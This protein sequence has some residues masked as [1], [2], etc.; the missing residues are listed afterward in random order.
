MQLRL[1]FLVGGFDRVWVNSGVQAVQYLIWVR[2]SFG[3]Y[4]SFGVEIDCGFMAGIMFQD[5]TTL[6]LNTQA[7]KD[8]ID[9]FVERYKDKEIS[10]VAGNLKLTL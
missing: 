6:L 5:I 9:L 1:V 10:V 2:I 3:F 7:F 4:W 8:T